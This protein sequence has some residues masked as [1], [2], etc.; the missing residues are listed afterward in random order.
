M[1]QKSKLFFILFIIMFNSVLMAQLTTSSPYSILGI[2]DPESLGFTEQNSMGDVKYGLAT[3]IFINP[4]NPASFTMLKKPVFITDITTHSIT[5]I[6][7]TFKQSEQNTYIR[8]FS[9]GFPVIRKKNRWGMAFGLMP[10]TKMGYSIQNM[11]SVMNFGEVIYQYNGSGEI[12]RFNFGN[13][14]NIINNLNDTS[15]IKLSLGL[16]VSYLFGSIYKIQRVLPKDASYAFNTLVSNSM[17]ISDVNLEAGLLYFQRFSSKLLV[18]AGGCFAFSD[19]LKSHHTLLSRS[20]TG[21]TNFE[22]FKDTVQ[23]DTNDISIFNP[24]SYGLGMGI[25]IGKRW[26]IGFDYYKKDWSQFSISDQNMGLAS[27]QQFSTGLQIQPDQQ[28]VTKF[29]KTLMYRGGFRYATTRLLVQDKHLT[30]YGISFGL[31]IPLIKAQSHGSSINIGFETG[32]RG[33][34]KEGIILERFVNLNFGFTFTPHKFD[35]W[36]YKRKID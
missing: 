25:Y 17:H 30:E 5:F 4:A 6:N 26:V 20:Y 7:D 24:L 29:F 19:S 14:L 9:F 27:S 28:A 3:P 31:G 34:D 21:Q 13:G 11:D 1:P 10:W 33:E 35:Q 18:S 36:F 8:N 22:T 16:N 23:Y 15:G 2:G 12:N 32:K